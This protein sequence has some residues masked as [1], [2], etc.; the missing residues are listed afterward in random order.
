LIS[1]KN[2]L[3]FYSQIY[4]ALIQINYFYQQIVL[5]IQMPSSSARPQKSPSQ[6]W[7]RFGRHGI[8]GA[9]G[10]SGNAGQPTAVPTVCRS[11]NHNHNW[12]GTRKCNGNWRWI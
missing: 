3:H 4:F 8:D 6:A 7:T 2:F 1:K 11:S 5:F 9:I 10:D 12:G